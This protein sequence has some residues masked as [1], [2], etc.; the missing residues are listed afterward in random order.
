MDLTT[1]SVVKTWKGLPLRGRVSWNTRAAVSG[2]RRFTVSFARGR[3]LTELAEAPV[4]HEE[5]AVAS[6][7]KVE[8]VVC[9]RCDQGLRMMPA[10]AGLL[11][12]T[13]AVLPESH[14]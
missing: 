5:G 8:S 14:E 1:L 12:L 6:K 4:V 7:R 9:R 2:E 13:P 11:L 3:E 10:V